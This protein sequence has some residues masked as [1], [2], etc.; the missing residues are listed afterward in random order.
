MNLSR[1]FRFTGIALIVIAAGV[2]AYGVHDLQEAGILPGINNLA[3]DIQG[4]EATSWYGTIL[5]GVFNFG[6]QMTV[7]E[8]VTYLAY[9]IPALYLFL[10]PLPARDRTAGT[11]AVDAPAPASVGAAGPGQDPADEVPAPTA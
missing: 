6:P 5:K 1:F 10:R 2:L 9:V 8:V 7:L 11:A 3:W 4:Y